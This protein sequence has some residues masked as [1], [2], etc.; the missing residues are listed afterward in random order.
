[1]AKNKNNTHEN[2]KTLRGLALSRGC[3]CFSSYGF[4]SMIFFP[5][6][7]RNYRFFWT[8]NVVD[9]VTNLLK[10]TRCERSRSF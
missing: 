7:S 3:F 5:Q 2:V 6:T 1:M 10:F 9:A 4:P 8:R